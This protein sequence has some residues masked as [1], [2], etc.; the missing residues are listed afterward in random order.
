[1]RRRHWYLPKPPIFTFNQHTPRRIAYPRHPAPPVTPP[2]PKI[3][4]VT[5]SYNQVEYIGATIDSVL[6]QKYP[7]LLYHVQD[8]GST[9]GAVSVL[10]QYRGLTWSSEPDAGQADAINKGFQDVDCDLM[11]YLNSDDILLPST[12]N[13]VANFFK[14][15]PDIDI[16]YGHRIFINA[17]G[18]EIGRVVYPPHDA[19]ALL[20][21]GYVPQET[22]FWR[23]RVSDEIGMFDPKFRYAMDWDFLLRAQAA[24]FRLARLPHF[25]GCFRVHKGQK[26]DIHAAYRRR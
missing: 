7:D 26:N 11:G 14:A 13:R 19:R 4:I 8:G 12:L 18:E 23:K 6:T 10:K 2:C 15:H 20:F 9:D 24:G 1:L 3:A 21:V 22:M 25:L 17:D 5:P 16:V